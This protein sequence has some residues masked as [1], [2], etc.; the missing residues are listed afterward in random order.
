VGGGLHPGAESLPGLDALLGPQGLP[1]PIWAPVPALERSLLGL[2]AEGRIYL[3]LQPLDWMPPAFDALIAN[4]LQRDASAQVVLITRPAATLRQRLLERMRDPYSDLLPRLWFLPP[5]TAADEPA[6]V[7]MADVLLD[8]PCGGG[9]SPWLGLEQGTPL[10][11]WAG[12]RFGPLLS[13]WGLG[14][15]VA[16]TFAAIAEYADSLPTRTNIQALL[17]SAPKPEWPDLVSWLTGG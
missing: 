2:P 13:A 9:L 17:E 6:L 5:V 16:P 8:V 1:P 12:S 10:L 3:C 14:A 7:A 4:L 11:T 15:W